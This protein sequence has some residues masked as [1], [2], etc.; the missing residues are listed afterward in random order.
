MT[1]RDRTT[2]T[3]AS[4]SHPSKNK[5]ND[6]VMSSVAAACMGDRDPVLTRSPPSFS[7]L[8]IFAVYTFFNT[9]EE[10]AF[11]LNM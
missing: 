3:S 2:S 1:L 8:V 9:N 5:I 10:F 7:L 11:D 4:H 6:Q